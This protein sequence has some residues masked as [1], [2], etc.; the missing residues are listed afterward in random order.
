VLKPNLRILLYFVKFMQL[1]DRGRNQYLL[2]PIKALNTLVI[3]TNEA[4]LARS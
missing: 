1:D 3:K 2:N 4:S